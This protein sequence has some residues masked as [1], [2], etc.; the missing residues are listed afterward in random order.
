MTAVLMGFGASFVSRH[1]EAVGLEFNVTFNRAIP[2]GTGTLLSSTILSA[3]PHA[4][5][6]GTLVAFEA[7]ITGLDGKR[8]L[9]ATGKAVVWEQ[10]PTRLA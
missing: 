8:Y 7:A 9:S 4:K 6:G 3:E 5:L 1:H 10:R 2:A